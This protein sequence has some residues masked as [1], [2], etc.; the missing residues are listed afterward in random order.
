MDLE[1][2]SKDYARVLYHIDKNTRSEKGDKIDWQSKYVDV[3]KKLEDSLGVKIGS[4]KDDIEF[5]KKVDEQDEEL[6]WKIKIMQ[7][8]KLKEEK[9]EAYDKEDWDD[10]D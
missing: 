10:D 8:A 5:T 1:L 6:I 2:S 9:E 7:K 3:I 4:K